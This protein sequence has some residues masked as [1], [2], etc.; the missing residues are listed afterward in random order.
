MSAFEDVELD[1]P[2]GD[3]ED[4]GC[5]P[6]RD[7][8]RGL[9]GARGSTG[10]PKRRDRRQM[11]L[12]TGEESFALVHPPTPESWGR[13]DPGAPQERMSFDFDDYEEPP[14]RFVPPPRPRPKAPK[15]RK[16]RSK[17]TGP[18]CVLSH[19]GKVV[20]CY[21]EKSVADRVAK[22]FGSRTGTKFTVKER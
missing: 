12:D 15:P 21:H 13:F 17:G 10:A 20:H 4:C 6:G 1:V 19:K 8:V 3:L 2:I 14:R 9:S 7:E 11:T 18:Y 16:P 5:G 22:S